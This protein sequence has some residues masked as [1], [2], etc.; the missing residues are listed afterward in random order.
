MATRHSFYRQVMVGK[1]RRVMTRI[2]QADQESLCYPQGTFLI[3]WYRPLSQVT[4]LEYLD[5]KCLM[6][7][8]LRPMEIYQVERCRRGSGISLNKSGNLWHAHAWWRL[9][10]GV[11]RASLDDWRALGNILTFCAVPFETSW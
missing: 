5:C 9:A 2:H 6:I 10:F 4:H 1:S 8:V 3:N 11:W 7:R